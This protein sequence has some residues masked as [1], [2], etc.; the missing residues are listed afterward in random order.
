MTNTSFIASSV[1]TAPALRAIDFAQRRLSDASEELSSG[2]RA[3]LD[4]TLGSGIRTSMLLRQETSRMAAM[5]DANATTSARLQGSQ[6]AL[7]S[8]AGVAQGMLGMLLRSASNQADPQTIVAAAR[9]GLST[10]ADALNTTMDGAHLFSGLNTGS[11]PVVDYFAQSGATARSAVGSAFATEFGVPQD[12]AAVANVDAS[13]MQAFLDSTFKGLFGPSAWQGTWS[14][15]SS[16]PVTSQISMRESLVTSVSANEVSF[17]DLTRAMTMLADLGLGN[18]NTAT[19]KVVIDAATATLSSAIT[20]TTAL[21]TRL[22]VAQN[23]V[24]NANERMTATTETMQRTLA[25]LES[26]DSAEV[27]QRISALS[28]NLEAAYAI[29]ARLNKLSILDVL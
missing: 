21:Q 1:I 10:I 19:R 14:A 5:A 27:S 3:D 11:A 15:A 24:T 16:D 13:S 9:Q 8:V 12:A 23:A 20:G 22:G 6:S 17:R 25:S 18:M 2:R 4:A 26:V 28:S 29:V 7:A